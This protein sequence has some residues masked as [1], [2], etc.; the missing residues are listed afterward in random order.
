MQKHVSYSLETTI[1]HYSSRATI[2]D[3]CVLVHL[4][5]LSKVGSMFWGFALI[6]SPAH[7]SLISTPNTEQLLV[8]SGRS[9][10]WT[11]L[12]NLPDHQSEHL[13]T[14]QDL[15]SPKPNPKIMFHCF[16]DQVLVLRSWE[17]RWWYQK[18]ETKPNTCSHATCSI[19][20]NKTEEEKKESRSSS[21]EAKL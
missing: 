8:I 7:T 4:C 21:A 18:E 12:L 11:S 15:L 13:C 10:R 5:T 14:Q 16:R 20:I 17:S 2:T 9:V 19:Y 1:T 3:V 6:S